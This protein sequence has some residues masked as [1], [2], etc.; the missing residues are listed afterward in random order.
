MKILLS[1]HHNIVY[2][3]AKGRPISL[4]KKKKK[5]MVNAIVISLLSFACPI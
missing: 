2:F 5:V 4:K 3:F 1:K